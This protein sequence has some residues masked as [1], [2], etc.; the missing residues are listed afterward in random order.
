MKQMYNK[1]ERLRFLRNPYELG[2]R[3]AQSLEMQAL[4]ANLKRLNFLTMGI[5]DGTHSKI[6]F[7]KKIGRV[8]RTPKTFYCGRDLKA[9]RKEIFRHTSFVLKPNHLS[10]GI[11]VRALERKGT[12]F[13][14]INGDV[15]S[16]DS[17]VDEC[18]V[19]LQLKSKG[20]KGFLI[21]ERIRSHPVFS[22]TG[23]ADIRVIYYRKDLLF[24]VA[25]MPSI[26][27][28]GYGN[29]IR[30]A[31][32]GIVLEG[33]EYTQDDRFQ[34]GTL[35]NGR[36]PCFDLFVAAGKK[37]TELFGIVFQAV[38]MT[39]NE[40][41][42]VVVMESEE[43]PQIEYYLTPRGVDW[44]SSI[45]TDDLSRKSKIDVLKANWNRVLRVT[46]RLLRGEPARG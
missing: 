41:G 7:K 37:V 18:K 25:R 11:G 17:L 44:I 13:V 24:A 14:D 33:G 36:L 9:I 29:I 27:S 35:L 34:K 2:P 10:R 40:D 22:T 5:A 20:H 23:M 31:D 32:W 1:E 3:K 30:G 8:V 45:I 38:D 19:I 15:L 39:V 16:A 42:E 6:F 12:G 43:M 26:K 46:G 28:Q 4:I 21:E